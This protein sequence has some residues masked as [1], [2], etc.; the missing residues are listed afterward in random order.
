MPIYTHRGDSLA[1]GNPSKESE[2]DI[3]RG[4]AGLLRG[5]SKGDVE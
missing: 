4:T 1:N 3:E 5:E 2:C